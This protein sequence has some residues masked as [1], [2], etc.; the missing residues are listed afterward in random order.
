MKKMKYGRNDPCPCGKLTKYKYC[1]EGK[2]DWNEKIK[3]MENPI[4]YLS[5]RGRNIFF[6][7]RLN[8][9]LQLDKENT[10]KSLKD[11]KKLFTDDVVIKINEALID[12]WPPNTNI[13]NT[14]GTLKDETT[15]L[16][17]GDYHPNSLY[18]AIIRHSIYTNKLLIVDPF[19]YPSSVSDE[20]NPI[21]NPQIYRGQTLR[22]VNFWFRMAPWIESG[23]VE[24]IRTPADFTK[25]LYWTSFKKQ[26]KK[27]EENKRLQEALDR[28]LDD[29]YEPI[30][31]E[32]AFRTLILSIPDDKIEDFY[33]NVSSEVELDMSLEE[34]TSFI[35]KSRDKDP[36]F[37][38]PL[39]SDGSKS[40][41][42]ILSSGANYE[43]ARITSNLTGS[44]LVTD[45]YSKWVEI[46][47]DRE[48]NNTYN[49]DWEP[50]VKA[51]QNLKLK[52]LNNLDL[53]HALNLRKEARL[54]NLRVFLKKVWDSARTGD[55]CSEQNIKLLRDE[56]IDEVKKAEAEWDEI[57]K[58]VLKRLGKDLS[59]TLMAT[60]PAIATGSVQFVAAA[61]VVSSVANIY[62]STGERK[63]F[64]DKYPAAFFFN[65]K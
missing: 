19:L 61:L 33:N 20:F 25:Y 48:S 58:N 30:K 6:I 16:Y 3:K 47:I 10:L 63:S 27:F 39:K 34:F 13:Q 41:L 44:Y 1:C 7:Q 12:V 22:N 17:V 57:D 64:P 15:G 28:T 49:N 37:L 31:R 42:Y 60:G 59:K 9:I 21:L 23:I 51:F 2:V 26:E 35:Y 32:M 36:D 24:I 4:P 55:P 50:F 62:T 18:K 29:Q 53:D 46:E 8:D 5:P 43:I 56:L 38:E 11:Y 52:Y 14:L 54:E 45:I 40:E 65:L